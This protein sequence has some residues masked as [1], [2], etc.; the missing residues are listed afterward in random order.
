[1]SDKVIQDSLLDKIFRNYT[2]IIIVLGLTVQFFYNS[3]VMDRAMLEM[4]SD[5]KIWVSTLFTLFLHLT[6]IGSA[7]DKSIVDALSH[8]KFEL[9]DAKNDVM[10]KDV[11]NNQEAFYHYIVK[12]NK[13]EKRMAQDT[14]LLNNDAISVD[15]LNVDKVEEFKNLTYVRYD[16][17]N[18]TTPIL[19]SKNKSGVISFGANFDIKQEKR[20]GKAGKTISVL[21]L[22]MLQVGI[23]FSFNDLP[24]AFFTLFITGGA[25]IFSYLFN[26]AKPKFKLLNEIPQEVKAK[27]NLFHSFKEFQKGNQ[28][29]KEDL[30]V[31]IKEEIVSETLDLDETKLNIE[32]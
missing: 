14:F 28:V 4:V 32:Q 6:I 18:F 13:H 21:L 11:R 30:K 27:E 31:E 25:L 20:K 5:W 26:Y 10:I 24:N 3:M 16:I 15:D 2:W 7:I 17:T 8:P 9:A 12:L 1:M 22:S 29:L 19:Y 23:T